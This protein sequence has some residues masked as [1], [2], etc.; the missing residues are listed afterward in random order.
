MSYRKDT[1]TDAGETSPEAVSDDRE[2][3]PA[4]TAIA[5]SKI[6]TPGYYRDGHNRHGLHLQ[7]SKAGTKSWVMRFTIAGRVREMGLGSAADVSLAEARAAAD[8]ARKLLRNGTDPIED[9]DKRRRESAA[10]K[11]NTITFTKAAAKYVATHAASWKH[12]RH[13]QQWKSSMSEY[14]EPIIGS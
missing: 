9:R 6:K 2:R 11:A 4:L 13:V 8:D 14:C 12:P 7:V 3:T 5:V 1:N 10:A